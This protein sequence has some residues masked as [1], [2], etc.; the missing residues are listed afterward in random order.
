MDERKIILVNLSKGEL[1]EDSS[2]LLGAL[3]VST[4]ALAA[5]SRADLP[6]ESRRPFFVYIDEFQCFTTHTVANM[7][8]EL[9][10][11]P[12]DSPSRIST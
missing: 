4:L 8:S 2:G 12:S 1:G 9:G 11:T 10:S 3:L 5:F 7:V 6:S